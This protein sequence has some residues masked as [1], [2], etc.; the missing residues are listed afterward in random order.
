[1]LP[2]VPRALGQGAQEHRQGVVRP[3]RANRHMR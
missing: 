2:A 1:V 3:V